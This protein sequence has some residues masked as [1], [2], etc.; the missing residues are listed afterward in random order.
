MQSVVS[1]AMR[2]TAAIAPS[3]NELDDVTLARAQHGD[4]NAF[5]RLVETY[6]DAVFRLLWRVLG[7]RGHGALVEDLAQETFIGVH[8]SLP[9]FATDGPARLST[10]ILTIAVRTALKELRKARLP[11]LLDR[12][13]DDL[14]DLLVAR[15]RTEQS[16]EQR[17]FVDALRRALDT[18][19]PEWRIVFVLRE[20]HDLEYQEIARA[21]DVDLGTV[22]SRLSRAREQIREQLKEFEP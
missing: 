1:V 17:A 11:R 20:Y 9:R 15:D 7:R 18:L 4:A 14:A 13:V 6:Q 12:H 16:A 8:R 5:Q 3:S 19:R 2:M 10:W 21:L 22:K